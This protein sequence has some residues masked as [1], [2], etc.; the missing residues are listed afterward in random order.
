MSVS[1]ETLYSANLGK[2]M[3][4]AVYVPDGY[5]KTKLPVL[6]FLHG[7]SGS[8][9]ILASLGINDV[10]EELIGNK[11]INP[12]IVVC[13]N[14]DNSRGINSSEEYKEVQGKYGA[15][16]LGLYEDYFVKDVIPFIEKNYNV[17]SDRNH[18]M[19][20]GVSSGGYSALHIGMRHSGLFS[21]I[22]AHMPAMDLSYEDEDECYFKDKEMWDKYNPINIAKNSD[23]DNIKFY[24]D[25]G[26]DDEGHFFIACEK[27]YY[28]LKEKGACVEYN[29]FEGHHDINYVLSNLRKYLAFYGKEI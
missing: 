4:V 18:R 14:M 15:V 1:I 9:K 5:G 26:N 7:R 27:L 8:E 13:P 28:V 2:N 23:M 16:H 11:S 12:F 3:N 10:M 6:Y 21:K 29:L 25:D 17:I 20:G 19:I 22:G 24:I